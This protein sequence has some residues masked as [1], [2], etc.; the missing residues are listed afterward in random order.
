MY[1]SYSIYVLYKDLSDLLQNGFYENRT[2]YIVVLYLLP[3]YSQFV[4]IKRVDIVP[5]PLS[6]N[7]YSKLVL[8][9]KN[10]RLYASI[11]PHSFI[12]VKPLVSAI[13]GRKQQDVQSKFSFPIAGV[14]VVPALL[15]PGALRT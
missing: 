1:K 10:K 3:I 7:H 4:H 15:N 2:A 13:D 14:S 8:S 12:Q 6:K 11:L 9:S 5:Y